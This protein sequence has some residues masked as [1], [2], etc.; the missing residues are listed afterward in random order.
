[1][2]KRIFDIWKLNLS[3]L[4]ATLL[5]IF[6][7]WIF[8]LI[9]VAVVLA[10]DRTATSCAIIGTF[11][12]VLAGA[13]MSIILR[14]MSFGYN[15]NTAVSMGGTRKEFLIADGAAAY[16]NLAIEIAAILTLYSAEKA[17]CKV[18]YAGKECEDLMRILGDYR[19]VIGIVLFVPAISMFC[20]ALILKFQK[21]AY[22]T[23]Y[24]IWMTAF[25]GGGRF[26]DHINENPGSLVAEIC[27]GIWNF[28]T[29]MTGIV[30]ITAILVISCIFISGT[31][32]LVRKQAVQV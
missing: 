6:G 20:G 31:V 27:N 26:V 13:F 17:L 30:Q 18:L 11:I 1:M 23:L 16:L 24:A 25:I 21:A 9:I 2:V 8:G 5:F 12:A 3:E 28:V 19:I 29:E 22:W 4:Y 10:F 14:V 7:G 15:F 32:L